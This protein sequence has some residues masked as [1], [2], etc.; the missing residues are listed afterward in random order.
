MRIGKMAAMLALLAGLSGLWPAQA[1]AGRSDADEILDHIERILFDVERAQAI[2]DGRPRHND[3]RHAQETLRRKEAEL[4]RARIDAMSAATGVPRGRI[5]SMRAHGRT[6]EGIALDLGVSPRVVGLP[7]YG[8]GPW[9][10]HPRYRRW[11]GDVIVIKQAPPHRH[12]KHRKHGPPPWAQG[13]GQAHK[14]HGKDA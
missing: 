4:E 9:A 6:W 1:L 10:G 8:D 3:Y 11:H 12:D 2:L 7:A 5:V 14:R 13:A